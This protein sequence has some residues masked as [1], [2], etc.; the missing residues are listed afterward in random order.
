MSK[1][2]QRFVLKVD[3]LLSQGPT[4]PQGPA[5]P[6]G[7]SIDLPL[8]SDDVEYNGEIL[9]DVLDDL[10][11]IPLDIQS[12]NAT[13]TLYEKGQTLTSVPLTWTYNKDVQTQAI[14]GIGVV[15]PSL[16][17]SERNKTVSLSNITTN[18][19]IT[20]TADDDTADAN[21][22]KNRTV[23]LT[24]LNKVYWGIASV[25]GAINSAFVLSL[26][27]NALATNRLRSFTLAPGATQYIWWV[28][29]VAYG[30]PAFKTN[31]FN[32]GLEIV[33]TISL[34]NASGHTEDY[35]VCRSDNENL[36]S[37]FVEVL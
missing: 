2:K 33:A 13:P 28:S 24:F 3:G 23:T 19:I 31:G 30:V 11:Y 6:A 21:P 22:A 29:P 27:S 26:A 1:C 14:S 36:G 18:T 9:T 37:T 8:S 20:L 16:L 25:P 32:G 5:G 4:G 7:P 35:Y 12:F 17:P 34:T 15:P 10:L